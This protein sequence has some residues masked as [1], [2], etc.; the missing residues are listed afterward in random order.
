MPNGISM[1][2]EPCS[3]LEMSGP[4]H[5]QIKAHNYHIQMNG[6]GLAMARSTIHIL[7]CGVLCPRR[8][9]HVR[10]SSN[11]VAKKVAPKV[12]NTKS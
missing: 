10:N 11:V 7:D 5:S 2:R 6:V 12:V 1:R 8:V 3:K 4:S 9:W